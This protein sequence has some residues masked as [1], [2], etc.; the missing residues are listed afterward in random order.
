MNEIIYPE[1]VSPLD[2]L[3]SSISKK[4]TEAKIDGIPGIVD[5]GFSYDGRNM[6]L[7]F[8][9]EHRYGEHDYQLLRNEMYKLLDG[10]DYLYL[11]D[12][13]LPT[14][15]IKITIDESFIPD[16]VKYS[17]VSR[18]K[19]QARIAGMPFWKTKYS[20]QDLEKEGF[21]ASV[22]KYGLA[23]NIHQDYT[24][25]TF[26]TETFELWNGGDVSIDPRNMYLEV[27]VTDAESRGNAKIKNLTTNETFIFNEPLN[28]EDLILKNAKVN[29][30]INNRLRD[31]NRKLITLNPGINKFKLENLKF[32]NI[33]FDFNFNYK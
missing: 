2:F 9:I 28:K 27:I 16:R 31:S 32:K 23:D 20:T 14:R 17:N 3:I 22:S 12:D 7:N 24:N 19:V 13:N 30:G 25:Y 21:T 10:E 18:L 1:G 33:T 15:I 8:W 29:V 26:K 5:Y 4:R 11:S 6:T